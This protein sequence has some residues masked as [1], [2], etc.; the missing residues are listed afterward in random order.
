[1]ARAS[2]LWVLGTCWI[3]LGRLVKR[4]VVGSS[5]GRNAI[6]S[7]FAFARGAS[8]SP[9]TTSSAAHTAAAHLA[10]SPPPQ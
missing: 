1:V 2:E 6:R 3:P 8:G 5:P 4:I 10:L 9:G 7:R